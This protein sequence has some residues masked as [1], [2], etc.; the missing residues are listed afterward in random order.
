MDDIKSYG[1]TAVITHHVREG[2][3]ESY[4]QW[5]NKIVPLCKTYPGHLDWQVI[6]PIAG[7]TTIYTVIIRFDTHDHL[8]QWMNS[9]DRKRLL[10]EAR[11][12]LGAEDKFFTQSGLDFLFATKDDGVKVQAPKKWKQ[13]LVTW[14][15]IYP[16]SLFSQVVLTPTLLHVGIPSNRYLM[17]FI[18]TGVI[19]YLMVYII[20]PRF[21]KLLQRWLYKL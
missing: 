6:R 16:V 21:T 9:S 1:A 5:L 8:L 15:A 17:T 7:L 11:P 2:K 13:F 10:E 4:E 14:G 19:V 20:M 12:Y 3:Q 18:L